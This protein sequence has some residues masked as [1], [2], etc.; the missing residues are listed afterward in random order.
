MSPLK[1]S[2]LLQRKEK[3]LKGQCPVERTSK[4]KVEYWIILVLVY[5]QK[6]EGKKNSFVTE[7]SQIPTNS[8]GRLMHKIY[9]SRLNQHEDI[10]LK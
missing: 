3:F 2:Q 4:K 5:M 9:I 7:T 6:F 10:I 1:C 8:F